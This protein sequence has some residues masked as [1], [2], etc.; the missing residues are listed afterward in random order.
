MSGP[1]RL[2]QEISSSLYDSL[3]ENARMLG[4][5]GKEFFTDTFLSAKIYLGN[6]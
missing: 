1:R 4:E 6:F 2:T 3:A 5:I